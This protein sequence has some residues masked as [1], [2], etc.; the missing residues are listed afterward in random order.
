MPVRRNIETL[1]RIFWI[2]PENTEVVA[3]ILRVWGDVKRQAWVGIHV[4]LVDLLS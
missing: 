3:V 2:L 1:G 4:L